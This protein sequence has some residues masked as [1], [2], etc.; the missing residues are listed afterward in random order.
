MRGAADRHTAVLLLCCAS[1]HLTL[2]QKP[3]QECS[4]G[5]EPCSDKKIPLGSPPLCSDGS[6]PACKPAKGFKVEIQSCVNNDDDCTGK[7]CCKGW[8]CTK[9][10]SSYSQCTP[11]GCWR[12]DYQCGGEG[13]D[14]TTTCCQGL[15][16]NAQGK[17]VRDN[18]PEGV[19][20]FP[21][22][23]VMPL[24]SCGGCRAPG[25]HYVSALVEMMELIHEL[26]EQTGTATRKNGST[27]SLGTSSFGCFVSHLRDTSGLNLQN[28]ST[29]KSAQPL[30]R[31]TPQQLELA[32]CDN[33][34]GASTCSLGMV[35]EWCEAMPGYSYTARNQ[36]NMLE[37]TDMGVWN[38]Y[39]VP[40]CTKANWS[41]LDLNKHFI[42]AEESGARD[43]GDDPPI[44][45]DRKLGE[46]DKVELVDTTRL[47]T[48]LGTGMGVRGESQG[49]PINNRTMNAM[50]NTIPLSNT[51][52]PRA[53]AAQCHEVT[54]S[55]KR[56]D[57]WDEQPWS[58]QMGSTQGYLPGHVSVVVYPV[59]E[60]SAKG[61]DRACG[62]RFDFNYTVYTQLV[63]LPATKMLLPFNH[64]ETRDFHKQYTF[65]GSE[66]YSLCVKSGTDKCKV[67]AQDEASYATDHW[68][69]TDL[70]SDDWNAKTQINDGG[71]YFFERTL[72]LLRSPC[73][74]L[75][76]QTLLQG[77]NH[78]CEG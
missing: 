62:A 35:K 72:H 52:K 75:W 77:Q 64:I 51:C 40:L 66:R 57:G 55:L 53:K 31:L 78:P 2:Q 33:A 20:A 70:A 6:K 63:T 36:G 71:Q 23:G 47:R 49:C 3:P 29:A 74:G 45:I 58:K 5:Q 11:D 8:Q 4:Q 18:A 19:P 42:L 41:S 9:K 46:I 24:A 34:T 73:F 14:A 16:C 76:Y 39:G 25:A 22:P 50:N 26:A 65:G 37:C 1:V 27:S 28:N 12:K 44:T 30:A 21:P 67:P 10:D 60:P 61:K 32:K 43:F 15:T 48:R 68:V 69:S 54:Y 59:E 13:F 38:S 7:S 56:N 17:C